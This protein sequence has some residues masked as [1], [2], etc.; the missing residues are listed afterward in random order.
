MPELPTEWSDGPTELPDTSDNLQVSTRK[1]ELSRRWALRLGAA[2][3]AAVAVG[4]G[5][6]L[7]MPSLTNRGLANPTGFLDAASI[8]LADQLYTEVF[9][10]SPLILNP[11]T[12]PM[13]VLQAARPLSPAQ[14]AA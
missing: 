1:H 9:P 4:V 6:N 7:V 13:P 2:G 12:D 14:V 8:A 5:R 11:F 10:T 3:T